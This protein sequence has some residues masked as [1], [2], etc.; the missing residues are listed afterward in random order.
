MYYLVYGISINKIYLYVYEKILKLFCSI[1]YY[2]V[3]Y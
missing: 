1:I 3:D 2:T